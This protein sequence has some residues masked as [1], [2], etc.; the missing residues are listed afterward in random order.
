MKVLILGVGN[1]QVDILKE[2]RNNNQISKVYAC[3]YSDTGP[4]VE[5]A[6]E[7]AKI[8]I[9]D[10]DA[11]LNYAENN[12]I[13]LIYS[14]GSDVAI[15]TIMQVSEQLELPSFI[16]GELSI[17]LNNKGLMRKLFAGTNCDQYNPLFLSSNSKH[18]LTDYYK[19]QNF[20]SAIIKP[21]D[22]QGQRGV[23]KIEDVTELEDAFNNAVKYSK[24]GEVI[25]EQNIT[26]QEYSVNAYVL[27]SEVVFCL[28]SYRDVYSDLPGGI[29]KRHIFTDELIKSNI[30]AR[31]VQL[32]KDVISELN[33]KNGPVYFQIKSSRNIC[34]VDDADDL[35][36]FLIE[37]APRFD[38]CHLWRVINKFCGVNLLNILTNHLISL[39]K[40]DDTIANSNS[41]ID[42][43]DFKINNNIKKNYILEFYGGK[44]NNI[45]MTENIKYQSDSLSLD[46]EQF[47]YQDNEKIS[48]I[49]G[50]I[51]KVG[52]YIY[53]TPQNVA[54]FGGS[55]LVG[56]SLKKTL[57]KENIQYTDFS[58][59]N[60]NIHDYSVSEIERVLKSSKYDSVVILAAKKVDPK[61]QQTLELYQPNI[62]L[63]DNILEVCQ[64]LDIKN[65][66]FTSSRLVYDINGKTPFTETSVIMPRN[67]YGEAKLIN[68]ARILDMNKSGKVDAKILRLSQ[69]LAPDDTSGYMLNLFIENASKNQDLNIF[70]KSE[71]LRDYIYVEDVADGILAALINPKTKGVFNLASGKGVSN[72]DLAEIIIKKL[73][74]SSKVVLQKDKMADESTTILDISKIENILSFKPSV[75][76]DLAI[77]KIIQQKELC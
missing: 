35:K 21:V 46:Y 38:G 17:A 47:Y 19:T 61:E 39:S 3:S 32:A 9:T 30:G 50:Y 76:L 37:V 44:T 67:Y 54:I 59:S 25:L 10:S 45:F 49:N 34:D 52:Y 58:R 7:Y 56:K 13:D 5:F 28:P 29:I 27:N 51:E 14:V 69:V 41:D 42:A 66:I 72:L 55:G 71:G 75:D 6:D 68:E 57:D 2:M 40:N 23:K 4:G 24:A 18:H 62:D 8:D 36:L 33:I 64:K 60:Q 20:K 15:P 31:I 26:G 16:S 48:E 12:Q 70:G 73:N 53:Q 77:E 1:A 43:D 65:V 63:V 22:S 11:V 74:S